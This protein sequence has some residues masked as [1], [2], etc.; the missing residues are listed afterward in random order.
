MDLDSVNSQTSK[1]A[2]DVIG[3]CERI[4]KFFFLILLNYQIDEIAFRENI[5]LYFYD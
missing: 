1:K 5:N 4:F 2:I 3:F